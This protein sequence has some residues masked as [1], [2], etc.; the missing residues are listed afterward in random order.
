MISLFCMFR[1]YFTCFSSC[2]VVT[3]DPSTLLFT[4]RMEYKTGAQ[5]VCPE[6]YSTLI[7]IQ[8][9]RIEDKKGWIVQIEWSSFYSK[10]SVRD[11]HCHLHFTNV[12]L[13]ELL[14][15]LITIFFSFPISSFHSQMTQIY[16]ILINDSLNKISYGSELDTYKKLCRSMDLILMAHIQ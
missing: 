10:Y 16:L 14:L 7:G 6:L 12:Q 9:G 11:V 2:K 3:A 8:T 1:Y 5:T 4:C 15:L 13:L